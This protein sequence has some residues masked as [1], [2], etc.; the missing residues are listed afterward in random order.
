MPYGLAEASVGLLFPPLG[1]AAP[2]DAV[3][4]EPFSLEG[5]AL[6]AAADD[7]NALRFV[8]CGRPLAWP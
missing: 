1:R 2:V 3:Q 7:P 6:P 4:R 8:G 5:R